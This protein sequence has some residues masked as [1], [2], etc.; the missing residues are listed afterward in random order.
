MGIKWMSLQRT[1]ALAKSHYIEASGF[2]RGIW[3]LWQ[4]NLDI[5]VI[6][7]HKKF[8]HMKIVVNNNF[9][10]WLTTVYASLNPFT[11]KHL[12]VHLDKIAKTVQLLWLVGGDFNDILYAS[13]K[14]G[15]SP[16]RSGVCN[17]FRN[18]FH[19][20]LLHDLHFKGPW[21]TWAQG[22]LCKRIDRVIRNDVWFRTF[23]EGSVLHIPKLESDHRQVL[24][25]FD[26]MGRRMYGPKP[27]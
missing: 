14:K 20:N 27:L 2:S 8:V 12:W 25:R 18:W 4:D 11:R 6:L 26:S 3:I 5:D 10:S 1:V 15:G 24:A 9:V 23:T 22:S 7:N 13:E 19:S 17:L 16:N 21:F